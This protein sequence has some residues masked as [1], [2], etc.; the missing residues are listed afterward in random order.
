MKAD[1]RMI[2]RGKA[3]IDDLGISVD[4][5]HKDSCM[6]YTTE[7]KLM[8]LAMWSSGMTVKSISRMLGANYVTVLRWMNDSELLKEAQARNVI[9]KVKS[10]LSDKHYMLAN[11]ILSRVSDD[12][13]DGAGLKEKVL[14][15]SILI[16]KARLIEGKST[17]NI[18][19]L[20]ENIQ[21]MRKQGSE[22]DDEVKKLRD[23]LGAIERC[24]WYKGEWKGKG[25]DPRTGEG[26]DIV[27]ELVEDLGGG[28]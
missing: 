7:T 9:E 21:A 10:V 3:K 23:E 8:A 22:L 17:D 6:R 13:I 14:S 25:P 4:F 19:V 27:G 20:Y 1:R 26:A 15:S 16:D 5:K 18:A 11:T 12:D 28:D 24:E 2:R